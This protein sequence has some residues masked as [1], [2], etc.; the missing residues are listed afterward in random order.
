MRI[1]A[2]RAR[3]RKLAVPP[4]R[5]VRPT[6]DRVREALFSSLGRSVD[7]AHVLDLFAG[8]GALGLEALSRGA[9][10]AV[11]VDSARKALEAL[12]RNLSGTGFEALARVIPGDA[13]GAL[14]RLAREGVRFD[15]VFL[16]PPYTSDLRSRALERLGS[17]DLLAP[18]ARVVAEHPAGEG[19][20]AIA[21]LRIIGVK[22]YGG[23][24]LTLM[25]TPGEPG[26]GGDEE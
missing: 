22:R 14:D 11:F 20:A 17:L 9:A 5:D 21:G 1:V 23:T 26:S 8:S 19:T 10:S 2:G 24:S 16:D 3:G 15:L 18:G 25:E 13:F 4:G 7:G 6:S 12:A